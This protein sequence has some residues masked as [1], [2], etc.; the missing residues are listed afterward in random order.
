MGDYEFSVYVSESAW[1]FK[2]RA[3]ERKGVYE[4]T[5]K[6]YNAGYIEKAKRNH[7]YSDTSGVKW[8]ECC[9]GGHVGPGF[10]G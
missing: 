8:S 3:H 9:A 1:A 4:R 7:D 2:T 10:Y 6:M 5:E